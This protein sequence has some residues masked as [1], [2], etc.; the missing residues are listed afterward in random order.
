MQFS[1]ILDNST[2]FLLR[3]Y[4]PLL[5]KQ[6]FLLACLEALLASSPILSSRDFGLSTIQPSSVMSGQQKGKNMVTL[7]RLFSLKLFY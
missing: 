2:T 4:F 7:F 5:S 6:D 1:F 3:I